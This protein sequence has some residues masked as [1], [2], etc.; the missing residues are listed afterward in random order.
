MAMFI[1]MFV[2]H[3]AA[4]QIK[5]LE[6]GSQEVVLKDDSEEEILLSFEKH[7]N[8]YVCQGT[9]RIT[10]K[11]LVNLMRKAVSTFKGDAIVH[12]IYPTY[13][14][15]YTYK[16]G[17]VVQIVEKSETSEKVVFEYKDTI[18]QL[19]QLFQRNEVEHEIRMIKEQI[20]A[21]LDLR[22]DMQEPAIREQID[23]RLHKLT[24]RLFVLE[25]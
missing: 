7:A 12:R 19:E 16:H 13:T 17:A 11:N 18:G 3:E 2:D 15:V 10:N 4:L 1:Q 22:N 9:C 8:L 6:N 24:H 25:A 5:V 14:M 20:N 21:M 23:E